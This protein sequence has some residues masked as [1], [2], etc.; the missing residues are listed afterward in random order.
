MLQLLLLLPLRKDTYLADR[1]G[2]EKEGVVGLAG[3]VG[4]DHFENAVGGGGVE[5]DGGYKQSEE[6]RCR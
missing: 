1:L 6:E 3:S 2:G 5:R 4:G